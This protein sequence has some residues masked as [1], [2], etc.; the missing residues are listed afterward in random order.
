MSGPHLVPA[1]NCTKIIRKEGKTMQAFLDGL[2]NVFIWGINI[3][4][5]NVMLL[6]F[7]GIGLLCTILTRGVQFRKFGVAFCAV[8]SGIKAKNT[9]ANGELK[10]FQ[11]LATALSSCVG[12]GNIV[13]VA[14]ALITGGPGAI[15]W[16]WFAAILGMAT[17]YSEIIVAMNFR[18]KDDKGIWRGGAMYTLSRGFK[19]K[20]K[21]LGKFLGGVFAFCMIFVSLI[22][23]NAVQSNSIAGVLANNIA[24]L[25]IST[26]TANIVIGIVLAILSGL[27]IIGGLQ[28]IGNVASILTPA[29]GAIYVLFG[30]IIIIANIG[31]VPAAF[32]S[33]F[34]S[35]FSSSAILGGMVGVTIQQAL[36]RGVSRG[37][38]SN[39]AGCGSA[40]LVHVNTSNPIPQQQALFGIVEVF[41]D[42]III[43][44]FTA[45]IIL[46]T[47][48]G[49]MIAAGT[50][51]TDVPAQISNQA[52]VNGLGGFGDFIV[53]VCLILFAFSTIIGW[54]WYGQTCT[55]YLFGTKAIPVF[56]VV[57][58]IFTFLGT[59]LDAP[60]LWNA[61]DFFNGLAMIP[62][63][64]SLVVFCGI[65]RRDTKTYID[66]LKKNVTVTK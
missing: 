23:C 8:F 9:N 66:P 47:G 39:E 63:L 55:T 42:T 36:M 34:T 32:A 49:D 58:V 18:E 53:T 4:F 37:V 12:T 44:T 52:W 65:T 19:G 29:M 6:I 57:H 10:P 13:G 25:G 41:F 64:I 50:L 21:P 56:L 15:F 54:N 22:S 20:W 59:I 2:N 30:L 61:T 40:P 35:A 1:Y 27:V 16:M 11:A 48:V 51:G 43:C 46:T 17:K 26:S 62:S 31:R 60:I 14:T 38:M 28:R 33:I 3:F 7:L 24:Q 45:L 5:G